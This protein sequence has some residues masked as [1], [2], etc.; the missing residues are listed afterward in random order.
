MSSVEP[1]MRPISAMA[2]FSSAVPRASS[3][4]SPT[5]LSV[6][7]ARRHAR[8]LAGMMRMM[9]NISDVQTTAAAPDITASSDP[10]NVMKRATHATTA[11]TAYM[12]M[13]AASAALT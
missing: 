8:K 6:L 4:I 12:G 10:P 1:I 9:R 13:S 5:G 2:A 11:R 3:I 7:P